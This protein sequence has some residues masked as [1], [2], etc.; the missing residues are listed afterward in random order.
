MLSAR[1]SKADIE[2]G[3]TLLLSDNQQSF[4]FNRNP[5]V[6]P[7]IESNSMELL[8]FITY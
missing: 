7:S 2:R 6:T 8:Y 3:L 1:P 4:A 5:S